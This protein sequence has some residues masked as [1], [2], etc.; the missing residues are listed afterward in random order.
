MNKNDGVIIT[1]AIISYQGFSN[2]WE[3]QVFRNRTSF[4]WIHVGFN[5]FQIKLP[6]H[7]LTEQMFQWCQSTLD[8]QTKIEVIMTQFLKILF[9]W[10][11]I[12]IFS[13]PII[14]AF[15][16][17]KILLAIVQY[18]SFTYKLIQKNSHVLYLNSTTVFKLI[19]QNPHFGQLRNVIQMYISFRFPG[20]CLTQWY[21]KW[22]LKFN[23]PRYYFNRFSENCVRK[24][25]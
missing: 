25:S 16:G 20:P 12:H 9:V 23:N 14:K 5:C 22:S 17:C 13:F 6:W 24:I 19:L 4:N 8:S 21:T 2:Y 1:S 7:L 15:I 10:R 18:L 11:N 3:Q